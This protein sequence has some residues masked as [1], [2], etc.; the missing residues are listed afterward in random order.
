MQVLIVTEQSL[1][2]KEIIYH[3]SLST[4]GER[5][6]RAESRYHSYELETLAV[7]RAVEHF[8]HFLY[9]RHFEV[10]TDC[11]SLKASKN[12]KDLTPRV[13]RWWVYLQGFDFNI[14]YREGRRMEHADYLPRNP[15]PNVESSDSTVTVAGT[16]IVK[17]VELHHGWL[18]VEQKRDQEIQDLMTKYIGN[19][20]PETVV[21]TYM[22]CFTENRNKIVS[23]LP[24][25]PRSLI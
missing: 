2:K 20:F 17:F 9:G 11:N 3:K 22:V 8:R 14:I 6:I 12:K 7:V 5:Q 21:N 25:V 10:Y 19:G 24:V 23:W 18:F 13:H 4:V 16:K 15:L 1:Y